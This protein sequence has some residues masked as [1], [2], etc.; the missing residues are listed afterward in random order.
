MIGSNVK[1]NTKSAQKC[2]AG[3]SVHFGGFVVDCFKKSTLL[4]NK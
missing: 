2:F 4:E 3:Y 1:K